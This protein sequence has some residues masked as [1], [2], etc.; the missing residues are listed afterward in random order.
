MGGGFYP[1]FNG[2][3][4]PKSRIAYHGQEKNLSGIYMLSDL[5]LICEWDN[6]HY[7]AA[8]EGDNRVAGLTGLSD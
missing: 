5:L 3:R 6:V 2:F 4:P 1:A 7:D 8:G